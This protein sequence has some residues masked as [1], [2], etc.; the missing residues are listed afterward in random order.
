MSDL[1]W[2]AVSPQTGALTTVCVRA[3]LVLQDARGGP[4]GTAAAPRRTSHKQKPPKGSRLAGGL[5]PP[6]LG[7]C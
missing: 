3:A 7:C 5:A 4:A 1:F 6:Q 2:A